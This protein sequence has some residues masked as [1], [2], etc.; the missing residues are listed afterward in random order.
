LGHKNTNEPLIL[1]VRDI[2][3]LSNEMPHYMFCPRKKK[4][5]GLSKSEVH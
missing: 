5:P 1:K 4:Y 2:I 3:F